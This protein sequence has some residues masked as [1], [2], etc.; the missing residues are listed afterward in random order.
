[1]KFLKEDVILARD[2]TLYR[3]EDNT[4]SSKYKAYAGIF[5]G[6]TKR[7]V[8]GWGTPKSYI[9]SKNAKIYEGESADAFCDEN[10]FYDKTYKEFEVFNM[11]AK[12][13]KLSWFSNLSSDERQAL[14]HKVEELADNRFC[15]YDL[16]SWCTQLVAKIELEKL[17][18]DGALWT[19]EDAGNPV[20]YQIWNFDVIKPKHT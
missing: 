19:E 17:G 2:K 12:I 14:N 20:Q 16:W 15:W 3:G 4:F 10:G 1:M 7:S 5:L 8:S 6:P 11:Y 18:Y 9:L 13:D